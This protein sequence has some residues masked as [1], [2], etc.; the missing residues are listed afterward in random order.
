M[1]EPLRKPFITHLGLSPELVNP[2]T[3]E[4]LLRDEGIPPSTQPVEK[5]Y[6][7][8][9]P[10]PIHQAFRFLRFAFVM[11]PIIAGVDKFFDVIAN[12][13]QYLSGPIASGVGITVHQFMM[14]FGA[15]EVV[16]GF[17]IAVFPRAFSYVFA[18]WMFIVSA[19]LI[20]LGG[21][22]EMVLLNLGLMCAAVALA[23]LSEVFNP[24]PGR[25]L[26]LVR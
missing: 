8:T 11:L 25:K 7:L 3:T 24:V 2:E 12:W 17:G 1:A 16:I 9:Y 4:Q 19:N 22:Y 6:K 14:L 26:R 10:E 15:I 13:D 18:G 20:L 5:E 23:Q 21:Y